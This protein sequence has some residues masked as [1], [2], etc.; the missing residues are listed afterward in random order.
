MTA[1]ELRQKKPEV[2]FIK[3]KQFVSEPKLALL[4]EAFIPDD[5]V[6]T[7]PETLTKNTRIYPLAVTEYPSVLRRMTAME[8]GAW[9]I[10]KCHQQKWPLELDNFQCCLANLEMDF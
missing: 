7:F 5:D 8:A 1:A 3:T 10:T 6:P 9:A 4:K 2:F